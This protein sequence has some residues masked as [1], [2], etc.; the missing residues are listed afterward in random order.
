MAPRGAWPLAALLL[1]GPCALV[2]AQKPS[3]CQCS[4]MHPDNRENCGFPGISSDTCFSS[5]CCFDSTVPGVPWCF[6]PLPKQGGL[7]VWTQLLGGPGHTKEQS[8]AR[9]PPHGAPSPAES[10]ECVMEVSARVNCGFPGISPQECAQRQCCFSDDIPQV[11]WCFLPDLRGRLSLLGREA[12]ESPQGP[13]VS[14][15]RG[16][17]LP[18]DPDPPGTCSLQPGLP[19]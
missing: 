1:L 12:S 3:P 9:R 5:G 15:M 16:S 18:P 17:S 7:G 10:Q 6:H 2:G 19:G 14:Q 8:Q 13:R 11:P 4:R